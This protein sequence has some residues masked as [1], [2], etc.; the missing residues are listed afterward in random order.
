[1]RT[2][3]SYL[4]ASALLIASGCNSRPDVKPAVNVNGGRNFDTPPGRK[5]DDARF[6]DGCVDKNNCAPLSLR[7]NIK[8]NAQTARDG[9]QKYW[10]SE[11]NVAVNWVLEFTGTQASRPLLVFSDNPFYK[12]QP[13]DNGTTWRVVWVPNSP[14]AANMNV[15]ARD[16]KRCQI[17]S[18]SS[19]DCNAPQFNPT[20]DF[21]VT[22]AYFVQRLTETVDANGNVICQAGAIAGIIGGVSTTIN[23]ET[24]GIFGEI[25]NGLARSGSCSNLRNFIQSNNLNNVQKTP[26]STSTTIKTSNTFSTENL[27]D[28]KSPINSDTVLDV[29]KPFTFDPASSFSK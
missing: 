6:N 1:M 17:L 18:E 28:I 8:G 7:A 26:A 29:N 12:M 4:F 13:V 9:T 15:F 27:F 24:N 22:V 23:K 21:R 20:Y 11:V 2:L 5:G 3:T 25:A 19:T 10:F 14:I 16:L